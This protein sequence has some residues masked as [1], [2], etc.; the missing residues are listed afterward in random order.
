M[1]ESTSRQGICCERRA[2][3]PSNPLVAFDNANQKEIRFLPGKGY[4]ARA[5]AKR[6]AQHPISALRPAGKGDI[7]GSILLV[8]VPTIL[9]Q[10]N[11]V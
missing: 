1:L 3:L 10:R 7:F 2:A 4:I 11:V 5:A 6:R 9:N 8:L